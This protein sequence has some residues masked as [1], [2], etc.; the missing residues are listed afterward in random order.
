MENDALELYHTLMQ[1]LYK[2]ADAVYTLAGAV[3]NKKQPYMFDIMCK[4]WQSFANKVVLSHAQ[5]VPLQAVI[6]SEYEAYTYVT[7]KYQHTQLLDWVQGVSAS[8]Q[9]TKPPVYLDKKLV[10]LNAFLSLHAN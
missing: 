2:G 10:I 1:A 5:N 9:D 4:L 3:S 8:L 7:Q 6:Q